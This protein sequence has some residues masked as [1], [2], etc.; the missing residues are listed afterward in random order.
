MGTCIGESIRSA[1]A[2]PAN[3]SYREASTLVAAMVESRAVIF[4]ARRLSI[5]LSSRY[6]AISAS[7]GASPA[8][9]AYSE[10]RSSG[11]PAP[12]QPSTTDSGSH[13]PAASRT[14]SRTHNHAASATVRYASVVTTPVSATY[15]DDLEAGR[16][17]REA[18][19][20]LR[21]RHRQTAPEAGN[22][23]GGLEE[24]AG[25]NPSHGARAEVAPQLPDAEQVVVVLY[26]D[27]LVA[28][29]H[30]DAVDV[31]DAD[32]CDCRAGTG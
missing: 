18:G 32:P 23:R 24:R 6:W 28:A 10:S 2:S 19:V 8:M 1:A 16:G 25:D 4:A 11:G 21:I 5:W 9:P 27:Q 22:G 7:T 20:E 26:G 30:E 31:R 17:G 14:W 15:D 29:L 3:P 13:G 12:S